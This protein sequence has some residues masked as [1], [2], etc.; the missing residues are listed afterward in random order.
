MSFSD[1]ISPKAAD[2]LAA[3]GPGEEGRAARLNYDVPLP[4]AYSWD[5]LVGAQVPADW[6][7]DG[8]RRLGRS[9][10][11]L[12]V[13]TGDEGRLVSVDR[14]KLAQLYRRLLPPTARPS[15]RLVAEVGGVVEPLL[16]QDGPGRRQGLQAEGRLVD[17]LPRRALVAEPDDVDLQRIRTESFLDRLAERE[18][19]VRPEQGT[20]E[21]VLP[22][23]G[24]GQS[25]RSVP[26][27]PV[28][29][30][31]P[32]LALVETWELR[33][34]LGDYGLGRT[35][36]TFSLL[37]GE[38]TT[39][40]VQTWRTEAA[41]RD[42]ATSI[43]DSS[44]TAAQSRFTN[45]VSTQTGA[46]YQDQGG[47][48]TSVSTSASAGVNVGL[49]HADFDMEAGFAANH[50]EASRRF[51][52]SVSEAAFE[53]A[54]QVNNSRRQS[55]SSSSSTST[56]SGTAT[57]VVR[58]LSNTNLRRVL[59]F[60][61]RELNQ[62]YRTEVVLRDVKVAFCNGRQG[63]AEIVPLPELGRLLRRHIKPEHQKE[64]ARFI[65]ALCAQRVDADGAAVATVQV[66]TDPQGVAY[67]WKPAAL[68]PDGTLEFDGDPLASKVRWRFA[69]VD[70]TGR[71]S[72]GVVM[73]RDTVVLRTDN[74]VVEALLGQAD[75]LD[76]YGCALQALDLLDRQSQTRAR[77]AET[78]RVTDA[79]ALVSA[80]KDDER[81][82]AW[83]KIFPDEPEIEV[84]PVAAVANHDNHN[85]HN[86]H[87]ER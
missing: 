85:G 55:I 10:L 2:H 8:A 46:A 70:G 38:R 27:D 78:R 62:T 53:H 59:N 42:D 48:A 29:Q 77:D 47:W 64:A 18:S 44:D 12:G 5:R 6:F 39:I 60:V 49:W 23:P 51:S 50:Q 76:P 67:Q 11:E 35:L 65:L 19:A 40:T 80:Q 26:V 28:A 57:T 79:L 43:F 41:T 37:P 74:L 13:V 25:I 17:P 82:D 21:I 45:S 4:G 34:H 69:P 52:T 75:A 15:L 72:R 7:V 16:D 31:V 58:E 33:S 30:A 9:L 71:E 84:V 20:A 24:I 36:Q 66:G 22:L 83:Q 54:S 14:A 68:K 63:S 61:F 81:V 32:R 73:H 87:V 86:G 3:F 1:L 56:A